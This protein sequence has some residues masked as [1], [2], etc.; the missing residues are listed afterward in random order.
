[1]EPH[2]PKGVRFVTCTF[3]EWKDGKV[4]E[5]GTQCKM[6]RGQMVRW[7]AE[8]RIGRAED[9]REFD[10][11]GYRFRAE[12]SEENHVVFLKGAVGSG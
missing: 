10:Q 7:M 2:L 3:G 12:L 5:K 1:M 8:N 4:I 11:L 6:A 9:L